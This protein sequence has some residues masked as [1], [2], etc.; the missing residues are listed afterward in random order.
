MKDH[1]KLQFLFIF[2]CALLLFLF[3]VGMF[4]IELTESGAPDPRSKELSR[5]PSYGEL[6]R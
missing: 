5:L 2:V 3:I 1:E 6:G 4:K